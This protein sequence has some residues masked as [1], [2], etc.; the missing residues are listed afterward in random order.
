MAYAEH[1]IDCPYCRATGLNHGDGSPCDACE[2][3]GRV[4]IRILGPAPQRRSARWG[5]NG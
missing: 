4:R 1:V 3:T 5:S 2:A